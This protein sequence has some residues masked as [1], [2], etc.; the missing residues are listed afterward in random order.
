[1]LIAPS[2]RD[3]LKQASLVLVSSGLGLERAWAAETSPVTAET[4]LGTIRGVDNGGIKTFKGVPYGANTMGRNRFMPPVDPPKWTGVRD[5]LDWGPSAPQREPGARGATSDLAVAAAGLP[6]ENENCLVLNVWTPALGDGRKRPVMLWCHGG[7]F[8]TG[9]GSSPVTDGTNLARRGDVVL[10]T[11]NHRLNVLGF[12]SLAEFG[13]DFA[14]SGDVGML[15][16][17]HALKWV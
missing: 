12:T 11:I 4:S 9:S 5:A 10:V 14:S 17:V 8:A 6:S 3:F 16:I 1:M 15:D 2:R 13:D 7:G